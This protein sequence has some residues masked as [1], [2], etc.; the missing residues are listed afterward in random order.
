M[1]KLCILACALSLCASSANADVVSDWNNQ[2]GPRAAAAALPR[3]GPSSVLDF[4]VVHLAMHDAVQAFERRYHPYCIAVPNAA[5]S[6]V[7]AASKAARDVLA[8]LFPEQV[9][10]IDQAY[11]NLNAGY[12]AQGLM[13]EADEGA[14]VG[15]QAAACILAQRLA[16]DNAKRATPDS[17]LGGTAPGEWRPTSIVSGQPVPMAADFLGTV[18]PFV[19][20]DPDQFRVPNTPPH[21]TSEAYAEAYEEVRTKGA[22]N[23]TGHTR[24]DDETQTALFFAAGPGVYWNRL[25]RDLV[26]GQSLN[27]GDSARMY[28]LVTMA[29]A[30]T[31]IAAWDSK[32]AYSFWRPVTAIRLGDDDGNA[33][34]SGNPAWAPF[35]NTPNYPDYPSGAVNVACVTTTV[36]THLLGDELAFTIFSNVPGALPRTYT[37]FSAVVPDVV[38]ARVFMGI[39]FRFADTAAERQGRR[40]ANWIVTRAL[41]PIQGQ[42]K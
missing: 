21:L 24:T 8:G 11:A 42:N 1:K 33:L 36:L 26:V 15:A 13:V 12:I 14:A 9:A 29:T 3:R 17:H 39:H 34:T 27:L 37:S 7:A 41:R 4:A 32:L 6:P 23:L 20:S 19:L 35:F 28:A 10:A 5:G 22:S 40:V 30:D 31:I 2:I 18:T 25:L 16:A 38:D